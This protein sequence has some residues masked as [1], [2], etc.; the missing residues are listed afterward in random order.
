[1]GLLGVWLGY[2][3]VVRL[4]IAE[5]YGLPA[6]SSGTCY[7]FAHGDGLDHGHD[8]LWDARVGYELEKAVC[9]IQAMECAGDAAEAVE[10]VVQKGGPI[11]RDEMGAW[12]APVVIY[13]PAVLVPEMSVTMTKSV[14]VLFVCLGNICR[15]PCAEGVMLHKVE[16]AGLGDV[17]KIDSAGTADW[18]TG[19]EADYR[20]RKHALQRGYKLESRARA[21]ATTDFYEFDV[22][23]AMDLANKANLLTMAPNAAGRAKVRMFCDFVTEH[24][25]KEVPDP[26]HDGPAGFEKVLD[27]VEDGCDGLLAHVRGLL[28]T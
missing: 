16:A 2:A 3:S 28:A 26:Y 23:L 11:H 8:L 27:L 24:E 20:M 13:L 4:E 9:R 12:S 5:F 18:H 7:A 19:N 1:L 17:V 15:S 22:I 25:E 10:G 21:A 6:L 14:K